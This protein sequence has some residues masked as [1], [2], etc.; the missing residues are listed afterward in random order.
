MDLGEVDTLAIDLDLGVPPAE[1]YKL[2]GIRE[3]AVIS[4]GIHDFTSCLAF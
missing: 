1:E 4:S 2:A 3:H